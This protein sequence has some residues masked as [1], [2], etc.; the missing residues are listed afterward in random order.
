MQKCQNGHG[1]CSGGLVCKTA[2]TWWYTNGC[3]DTQ[4][5]PE[6]I[7]GTDSFCRQNTSPPPPRRMLLQSASLH[8]ARGQGGCKGGGSVA[9]RGRP[10]SQL[11]RHSPPHFLQRSAAA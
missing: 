5:P 8:G 4:C 3:S 11:E 9:M 1:C 6:K 10:C 2:V 7:Q